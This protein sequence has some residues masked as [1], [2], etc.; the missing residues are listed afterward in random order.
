MDL[1]QSDK[2][3]GLQVPVWKE[4]DQKIEAAEGKPV[5]LKLI[6]RFDFYERAKKAYAIIHSG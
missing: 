6:P 3:K 2:D 4:Y 1:V 5:Q